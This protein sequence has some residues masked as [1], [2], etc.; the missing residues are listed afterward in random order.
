MNNIFSNSSL[1]LWALIFLLFFTVFVII[2]LILKNKELKGKIN[3]L[4]NLI[5]EKDKNIKLLEELGKKEEQVKEEVKEIKK[6]EEVVEKKEESK[7]LVE[8]ENKLEEIK[9][10]KE[11]KPNLY[12]N[13]KFKPSSV[14]PSPIGLPKEEIKEAV[15]NKQLE[16]KFEEPE[17]EKEVIEEDNKQLEINFNE[18]KE[19]KKKDNVNF[20]SEVSKKLEEAS[21]PSTIELTDYEKKQEEEAIISYKELIENKDKLYNITD[22]EEDFDFIEELKSFRNDL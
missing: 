2:A 20:M 17:E 22:D 11:E 8:K 1:I 16:I 21:V 18:P 14:V 13:T 5:N 10:I 12:N 15:D 19:E 9:D 7:E 6:K 3:S 4:N